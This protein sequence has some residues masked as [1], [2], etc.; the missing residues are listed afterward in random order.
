MALHSGVGPSSAARWMACPG[1]VTLS[2]GIVEEESPHAAEGTAAHEL[3]EYKLLCELGRRAEFEGKRPEAW[4]EEMDW[5]TDTYVAKIMGEYNRCLAKDQA[6]IFVGVEVKVVL[7]PIDDRL[8]GTVDCMFYCASESKLYVFDLKYGKGVYVTAEDNPQLRYYALGGYFSSN[9]KSI[10]IHIIQPRLDNISY[11]DYT[12]EELL[13]FGVELRDALHRVDELPDSYTPGEKQCRW[14]KAKGICPGLA[15]K[16]G[17]M[18]GS[19]G[20]DILPEGD[21]EKIDSA[22]LSHIYNVKKQVTDWY[23]SVEAIL[24][25]R[26]LA[27]EVV[28][29]AKLVLSG[30]AGTWTDTGTKELREF[31]GGA[32]I[33]TP[34][35]LQKSHP[36]EHT[37]HCTIP[38]IAV[39]I[40]DKRTPVYIKSPELEAVQEGE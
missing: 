9:A 38:L 21:V 25:S 16:Y 31:N 1:S 5:H 34:A 33:L 19:V 24:T 28:P 11:V 2:K 7:S 30:G 12:E 37:K 39:P 36:S 40:T 3:A 18:F 23:N 10:R 15:S 4:N 14:C 27:G 32:D 26:L 8:F 20:I 17:Q 6:E 35:G 22:T 29:Q 13:G